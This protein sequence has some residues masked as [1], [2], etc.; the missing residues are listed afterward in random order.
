MSTVTAKKHRKSYFLYFLLQKL[1]KKQSGV[2]AVE[3]GI[4]A[5]PFFAIVFAILEV[6]LVF[7]GSLALEN[8]VEQTSRLVKTGQAQGASMTETQ[9]RTAVCQN[10][11]SLFNCNNLLKL[12]LRSFPSFQSAGTYMENAN[13]D[14]IDINGDLRDDFTFEANTA[15]GDIILLRAYLEWDITLSFPGNGLSNMGN[16]NRLLVSTITFKNEPF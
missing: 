6:G 4:I 12:E 5:L 8:S 7:F 10:V 13:N 2:T 1:C 3:F 9:F 15:G 14:P 16:G 11:N